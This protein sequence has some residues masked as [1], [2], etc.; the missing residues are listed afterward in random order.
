MRPGI[1]LVLFATFT[2]AEELSDLDRLK[3]TNRIPPAE[4]ARLE[5]SLLSNPHD[6][7]TR[8]RLMSHYFQH[9]I[10]HPRVAHAIWVIEHHPA[11]KLAGSPI[12][13]V[14][15]SDLLNTRSDYEAARLLWLKQSNAHQG[16]AAVL[17]N[18]GRF[19][20]AEEPKRAE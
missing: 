8:A 17:A 14:T 18:A 4:V 15:R 9:A 11:S 6:L 19:F 20:A 16:N 5:V 2:P 7:S 10:S 1:L 12:A 3:E 13:G